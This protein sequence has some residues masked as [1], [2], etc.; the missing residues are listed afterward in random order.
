[1]IRLTRIAA[2]LAFVVLLAAVVVGALIGVFALV[3][4]AVL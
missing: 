3:K 2:V 4:G 1:M